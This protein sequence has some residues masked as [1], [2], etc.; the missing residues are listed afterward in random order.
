MNAK[1]NLG[2]MRSYAVYYCVYYTLNESFSS[3]ILVERTGVTQNGGVA[4]RE[5]ALIWGSQGI[6]VRVRERIGLRGKR[7]RR[8]GNGGLHRAIKFLLNS[9]FFSISRL[10]AWHRK[11]VCDVANALATPKNCLCANIFVR[12]REPHA[13]SRSGQFQSTTIPGSF[14][15]GRGIKRVGVRGSRG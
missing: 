7:E 9:F 5:S 11:Y 1:K 12:I 10:T 13:S 4:C 2:E 8:V 3:M 15:V 14:W 6:R